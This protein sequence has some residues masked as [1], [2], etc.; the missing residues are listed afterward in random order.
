VW[1][2]LY[3][4]PAHPHLRDEQIEEMVEA[5]FAL[6]LICHQ[7]R[8][9][10][11]TLA[12]S[13][14]ARYPG[15]GPGELVDGLIGEVGDL[16]RDWLGFEGDDLI[17]TIDLGEEIPIRELGLAACQETS[18]G[19]F[20]PTTVDFALSRDGETFEPVARVHPE[21]PLKQTEAEITLTTTI[22]PVRARYLRVHA[23]N[24][25]TIPDWHPAK[26]RQAWLFASEILVNPGK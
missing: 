26:G 8:H 21:V 3:Q 16:R 10:P 1:G 24:L 12:I 23:R 25:G 14:G 11:V 5:L 15:S 19:V 7:A 13:P 6:E 18:A 22:A 17:A 9:R 2:E 20:L 4:M